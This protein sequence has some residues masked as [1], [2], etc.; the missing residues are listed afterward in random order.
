[1]P[2]C[3]TVTKVC[4]KL[5]LGFFLLLS[6][7]VFCNVSEEA[8]VIAGCQAAVAVASAR[9]CDRRRVA[10]DDKR[11]DVHP[12]GAHRDPVPDVIVSKQECAWR[13]TR[14]YQGDFLDISPATT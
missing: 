1:M 3:L 4:V 10:G 5:V 2:M 14:F 12:S 7:C 8:W 13:L 9:S 6:L 11:E